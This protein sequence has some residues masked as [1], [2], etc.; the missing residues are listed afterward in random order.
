MREIG[1]LVQG[2]MGGGGMGGY[3][4]VCAFVRP[5]SQLP[6]EFENLVGGKAS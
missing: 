6:F 2:G 1:A 3:K 4:R 5:G